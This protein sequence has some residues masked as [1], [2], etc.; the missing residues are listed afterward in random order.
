MMRMTIW[1]ALFAGSCAAPVPFRVDRVSGPAGLELR[2][3]ASP[4]AHINARLRPA[5]ELPDGSVLRF[6][7]AGVTSD[8][9]Y[10]TVAPAATVPLG[11][12]RALVRAS[13]CP[14]GR[15]ICRSYAVP[16]RF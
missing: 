14:A 10:F 16:L 12:R 3:V 13:V 5:L 2:L 7:G 1:G 15:Q 9:A 11:V 8:S 6:Q 4:G